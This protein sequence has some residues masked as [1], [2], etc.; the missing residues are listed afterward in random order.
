MNQVDSCL[1]NGVD[2]LVDGRVYIGKPP[3][4]MFVAG[5]WRK[6][7]KGVPFIRLSGRKYGG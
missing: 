5:Q 4:Y 3:V 7:A 6:V 2:H 1:K